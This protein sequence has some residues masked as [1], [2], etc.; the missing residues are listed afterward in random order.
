M[1]PPWVYTFIAVSVTVIWVFANVAG[2]LQSEPVDPQIHFVMGGVV[3]ASLGGQAIANRR[4]QADEI[5]R[6]EDAR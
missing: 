1:L 3:G 2:I 6:D 5:G 4:R